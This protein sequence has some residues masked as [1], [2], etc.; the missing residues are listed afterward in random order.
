MH[1][2]EVAEE[3]VATSWI[4]ASS[5]TNT[6]GH[7]GRAIY[8]AAVADLGGGHHNSGAIANRL[9]MTQSGISSPSRTHRERTDLWPGR[10]GEAS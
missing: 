10:L 3:L 7:R 2:A 9:G 1:E 4:A 6:K 8:M 5:T